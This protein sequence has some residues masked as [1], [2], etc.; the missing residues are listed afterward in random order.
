MRENNHNL[1]AFWLV[2]N[3]SEGTN[4]SEIGRVVTLPFTGFRKGHPMD[5]SS[6]VTDSVVELFHPKKASTSII[7]PDE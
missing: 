5:S 4:C 6:L 1:L 7:P 2:R 3:V